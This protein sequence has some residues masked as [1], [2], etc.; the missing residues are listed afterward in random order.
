MNYKWI[1]ACGLSFQCRSYLLC[2]LC[3]NEAYKLL[4]KETKQIVYFIIMYRIVHYMFNNFN[5]RK[6]FQILHCLSLNTEK[7]ILYHNSSFPVAIFNFL[8]SPYR[9]VCRNAIKALSV[10]YVY[11]I[12][13]NQL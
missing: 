6:S 9:D 13:I 8:K 5:V 7:N 4:E 12:K 11:H 3:A 1:D 2:V 10:F